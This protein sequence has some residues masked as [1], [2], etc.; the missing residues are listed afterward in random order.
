MQ[1]QENSQTK[2]LQ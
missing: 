1:K 2:K